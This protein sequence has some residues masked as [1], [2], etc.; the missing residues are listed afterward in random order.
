M[1]ISVT[2]ALIKKIASLAKISLLPEEVD[3][4]KNDFK[5]ILDTFSVID[6][7]EVKPH[8]H[9]SQNQEPSALRDDKVI[10]SLERKAILDQAPNATTSYFTV[11]QRTP[12]E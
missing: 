12:D 4:Y 8:P 5:H 10:P 9:T 6:S 1:K 3:E 2:S 7:I 11:K